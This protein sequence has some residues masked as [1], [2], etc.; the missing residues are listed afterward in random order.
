MT[1][2]REPF[3]GASSQRAQT[4]AATPPKTW[5]RTNRGTLLGEMPA[6]VSVTAR[7]NVTAGLANDVEEV[8][9]YALVMKAAT[10]TGIASRRQRDSSRITST[11]PNVA[12]NSPR[13]SPGV[14][15]RWTD[16][17]NSGKPN[18]A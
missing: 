18:M 3:S 17:C 1:G 6:K 8:N 13:P 10:A 4:A 15:L 16:T 2:S 14:G 5:Q 7:A 11:S 12:T 9:Q